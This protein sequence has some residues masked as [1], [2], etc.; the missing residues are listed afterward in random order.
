MNCFRESPTH[1]YLF[2][3]HAKPDSCLLDYRP[4][5]IRP[6]VFYPWVFSKEI[7]LKSAL[8]IR[9]LINISSGRGYIPKCLFPDSVLRNNRTG[10]L[11]K[12]LAVIEVTLTG[13]NLLILMNSCSPAY[14]S[15][16]QRVPDRYQSV[17]PNHLLRAIIISSI[18]TIPSR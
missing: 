4:Y 10:R 9:C 12:L 7:F 17:F 14:G 11:K 15:Y 1:H 8:I 2:F 16:L 6:W 5:F 3:R 13:E 18:D